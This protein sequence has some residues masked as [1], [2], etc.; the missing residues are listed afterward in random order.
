MPLLSKVTRPLRRTVAGRQYELIAQLDQLDGVREDFG[1]FLYDLNV[2]SDAIHNWQLVLTEAVT[3][4]VVH[5]SANDPRKKVSVEWKVSG[6][7]VTLAVGDSGRGPSADDLRR[8]ELPDDPLET[9]GRGLY[10]IH[11]FGDGWKH[12]SNPGGYMQEVFKLHLEIVENLSTDIELEQALEEISLCY[13]SLAAFYRLGDTLI[14]SDTVSSFI[15]K[16]VEDLLPVVKAERVVVRFS[17]LLQGELQRG[18]REMEIFR[19]ENSMSDFETEVMGRGEEFIWESAREVSECRDWKDCG[20]GLCCPIKAGGRVLGVLTI[21]RAGSSQFFKAGDLSTART[22][23]DLFGI[24]VANADHEIVRSHEQLALRELEIAS[25][26]Q[27]RLLP[28][29]SP[30]E[31]DRYRVSVQRKSGRVIAGDYAEAC[32]T[33]DGGLA[34]VT[35]DVM[36]KGL[37][38]AFFAAT[39]RTAL[40]INLNSGLS[41]ERLIHSLNRILC[42]EVGELELFATCAIS[43]VR[44]DFREMQVVNAGHCPVLFFDRDRIIR[45]VDPSGPP[46]GL[47]ESS[48]YQIESCELHEKSG[49]LMLTDGLYEWESD[50]GLWGWDRFTEFL[51]RQLPIDPERLWRTLQEMIQ[52]ATGR[53]DTGDDKTMLFWERKR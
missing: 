37:S 38:A 44:P 25:E 13:E 19:T 40:H 50:G 34:L 10:L 31:T 16:A 5:G 17:G 22:F 36:G 24:A 27:Q 6:Q 23:A 21:A 20:A 28:I 46:L 2:A 32:R 4:A 33:P 41:L 9:G 49:M 42:Y 1:N 30:A 52:Q 8:P 51:Q 47:F 3:N 45:Q 12:W 11:R 43:M 39:F 48:E 7:T 15:E 53:V 14:Q 29:S 26:V 35:V 18:L